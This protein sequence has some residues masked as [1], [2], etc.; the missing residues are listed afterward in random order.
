MNLLQAADVRPTT[1]QL[2]AIASARTNAAKVMVRWNA[3]R[4]TELTTLNATLKT[5]GLAPIVP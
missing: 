5:A 3:L 2:N 4:T 1:V